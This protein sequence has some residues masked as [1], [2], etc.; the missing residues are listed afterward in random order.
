M[1]TVKATPETWS[2]FARAARRVADM[3]E[4]PLA[5]FGRSALRKLGFDLPDV[6]EGTEEPYVHYL[7]V[8]EPP[9]RDALA[10]LTPAVLARKE[11]E[12]HYY[13]ISRDERRTRRA[14][15]YG[16]FF[17]GGHWYL[18]GRDPEADGLRTFRL[19]RMDDV[20]P[21]TRKAKQPDFQVPADFRL[22][23][24]VGREAWRLGEDESREVVAEVLFLPPTSWWAE[25]QDL[26]EYVRADE[27]T[28]GQVR[29]FRV[30]QPDPFL[31]W[32]LTFQGQAR[33]LAP[34]GLVDG[35][36]DLVRRVLALYEGGASEDG[37]GSGGGG[38][39]E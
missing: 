13:S 5:P 37:G 21:N 3:T 23:D 34:R 7:G 27:A 39:D 14:H 11:V 38:G 33:P 12:F 36:R 20:Q 8:P 1:P 29:A 31:R 30:R 9:V 24:Y 19:S 17:Q 28:G 6:V 4:T 15:P 10:A 18:I 16:L 2:A 35:F 25:S 22:R 26:G 32:C